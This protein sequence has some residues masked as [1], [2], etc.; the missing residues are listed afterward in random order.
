[1][2]RPAKPTPDQAAEAIRTAAAST[3]W[4]DQA[5]ICDA[6]VME[7]QIRKFDPA[8]SVSAV[9]QAWETRFAITEPN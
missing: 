2:P 6:A 3:G 4:Q 5:A 9:A 1:M 8:T 7:L